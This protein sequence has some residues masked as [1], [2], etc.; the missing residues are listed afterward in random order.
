MNTKTL[1]EKQEAFLLRFPS[2]PG[3]I[4]IV[5]KA[6]SETGLSVADQAHIRDTFTA[7]NLSVYM[8]LRGSVPAQAARYL[9]ELAL[10]KLK[11]R[12]FLARLFWG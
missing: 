12:G 5:N 6:I 10:Q 3:E 11:S 7:E 2:N 4:K 8:S 1:G 9:R